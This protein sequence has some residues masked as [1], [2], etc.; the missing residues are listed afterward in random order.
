MSRA[1]KAG[2]SS[3]A[4]KGAKAA[5]AASRTRRAR[6]RGPAMPDLPPMPLH[7]SDL[8][9]DVLVQRAM[10]QVGLTARGNTWSAIELPEETRF[11]AC[12]LHI[13]QL[14]P[15][16]RIA[17]ALGV[18]APPEPVSG[19]G[20]GRKADPRR[21][22][23]AG[24]VA[25]R[26]LT[27]YLGRVKSAYA[28]IWYE[29]IRRCAQNDQLLVVGED[30]GGLSTRMNRALGNRVLEVVANADKL[31]T[32][33]P[34]ERASWLRAAEIVNDSVRMHAEADLKASQALKLKQAMEL[35]DK[36]ARGKGASRGGVV[37]REQAAEIFRSV[38]IGDEPA[39][40]GAA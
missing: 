29:E 5:P 28:S 9:R 38:L 40:G 1:A 30:V 10:T 24:K 8:Q 20:R 4:R 36:T 12:W 3:A 16:E 18:A 23:E 6:G 22:R 2:R 34:K 21:A 32:M 13:V 27:R 25:V 14:W 11:R 33:E 7:M 39:D 31:A 26:S 37:T 15:V 17:V 35:L 19:R